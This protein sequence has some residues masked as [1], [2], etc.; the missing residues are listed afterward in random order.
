MRYF[1][2]LAIIFISICCKKESNRISANSS[3]EPNLSGINYPISE[4]KIDPIKVIKD[5]LI[6]NNIDSTFENYTW[7]KIEEWDAL[8]FRYVVRYNKVQKAGINQAN[9][10]TFTLD[11]LGNIIIQFETSD[12]KAFYEYYDSLGV[13]KFFFSSKKFEKIGYQNNFEMIR[14][15]TDSTLD[16]IGNLPDTNNLLNKDFL[17]FMVKNIPT[18][19]T[20]DF[21][22]VKDV[23]WSSDITGED[24][25][26]F[27]VI[28][29]KVTNIRE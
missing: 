2:F 22:Y 24:G 10:N 26:G 14:I 25:F 29:N 11:S 27:E 3:E 13:P 15:N 5:Y 21:N 1:L 12:I 16:I 9:S 7:S 23:T 18:S 20:V 4:K 8:S 19:D 28:D 6:D 17:E